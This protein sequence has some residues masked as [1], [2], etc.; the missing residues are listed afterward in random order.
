[1]PENYPCALPG[2]L[3][4]SNGF[5]PQSL[6]RNNSVQNGPPRFRLQ[7]DNG[8]LQFNVAW[9]FNALEGQ[10]FENF[11]KHTL[12]NGSKS[13]LIELKV[14]GGL[15]EH[16]CYFLGVPSYNQIGKRWSVSGTLLA[17]ARAGLDECNGIS[18][19]NM[20]DAFEV[21]NLAIAQLDDAILELE[22][23]WQ[24]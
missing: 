3:V 15:L 11:H 19:V 14:T 17:I 6:V 2:V 7:A 4:N 13:F 21:P 5:S 16:E 1:M 20:F 24:A 23:L 9:S 12:A 22:N 18:L 8:W 10:V